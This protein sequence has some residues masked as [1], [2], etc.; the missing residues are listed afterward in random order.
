MLKSTQYYNKLRCYYY[1]VSVVLHVGT[2]LSVNQY[3]SELML[4]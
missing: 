4:S 2:T 3:H 1:S